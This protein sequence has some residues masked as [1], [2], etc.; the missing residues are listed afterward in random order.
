MLIDPECSIL[1][2]IDVQERLAPAIHKHK[3]VIAANAW[4]FDI[5]SH[6]GISVHAT[7]QYPDGLGPMVPQ[8]RNRLDKSYIHQKMHFS[9]MET[10]KARSVHYGFSH[11]V[12]TGT[13][14]HVCVQQTVLQALE[15]GTDV[16]VVDEAV[17]SR[18]P[19]DKQRALERMRVAGAS[20]VTREMVAFEW[21][22]R[23]DTEAFKAV[24]PMLREGL[25][26]LEHNP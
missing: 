9:W 1:L 17:G 13:E 15:R 6:L 24:Q 16:Y 22:R 14:A 25:P 21:L 4:L 20:I 5:A 12:V 2:C 19:L 8:L 26:Y 7:E 10:T 3:E 18:T 23:A 11:W